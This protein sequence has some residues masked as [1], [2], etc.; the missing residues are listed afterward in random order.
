MAFFFEKY[1]TQRTKNCTFNTSMSKAFI[2]VV[3]KLLLAH[4]RNTLNVT[5]IFVTIL[6][7]S[8]INAFIVRKITSELYWC[9]LNAL[10]NKT[11]TANAST[12][13]IKCFALYFFTYF[14]CNFYRSLMFNNLYLTNK[15]CINI[16]FVLLMF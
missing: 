15:L 8:G 14:F 16:I 7:S 2:F 3:L 10:I 13:L 11:P 9:N 5:K 1:C 4:S 6:S 12:D